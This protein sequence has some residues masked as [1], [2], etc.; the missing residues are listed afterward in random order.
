MDYS[1]ILSCCLAF[2]LYSNTFEA[3]FVYDDRRAIITNPDLQPSTPWL[4]IFLNDFWGTPMSD[5]GS[6]G[7]YR[8]LA[9][10]TFRL[11]YLLHGYEPF[12]YHLVNVILH[13]IATGLFVKI[14]KKILP[15]SIADTSATISGLLFAAHPIHTEAVSA[16]VGRA[17][18]L[19]AIAFMLSFLTYVSHVKYRNIYYF[20][21]EYSAPQYDLRFLKKW[22]KDILK[23]ASIKIVKK[24]AEI[25]INTQRRKTTYVYVKVWSH[26]VA[27][28]VLAVVG[29]LCKETGICV[30]GVSFI[31]DLIITSY[32]KQKQ[33]RSLLLLSLCT[34]ATLSARFY[35]GITPDFARADNPTAKEDCLLTRTFTFLYLP[36]FNFLL[37]VY[38]HPLSF[39][40]SMEAVP[41]VTGVLDP[42]NSVSLI[43]Y[44]TI[45][46]TLY[47]CY[48][49]MIPQKGKH[50]MK[51]K[52][53]T[54]KTNQRNKKE[55]STQCAFCHETFTNLHSSTCRF[56]N[57][58]N[59][60]N[61]TWS[62]C[63][64]MAV[65]SPR[66]NLTFEGTIIFSLT[67]LVIPFLPA[68]NMFFYVGFV[69]AERLLYLPSAGF[70]LLFGLFA[71]SCWK[72][73]ANSRKHFS[74]VF[75]VV[76]LALSAKTVW[77]NFDWYDEEAL[78][79]AAV[80]VNPPKALGNLGS[81]L[82]TA[83]RLREAETAYREALAYKPN[84]ADVHYNLGILLQSEKRLD[85]AILSFQRAI[86]FRST[87]A[88]A[89]INLAS[90]LVEAKR[91]EEA[92][93][94]LN[95]VAM[96][97]GTGL[98][99]RRQHDSAKVSALIQLGDLYTEQGR[100]HRALEI[101]TEAA[102]SIPDHY[103]RQKVFNVLGRT[104]YLLNRHEEAERW[105]RAAMRAGPDNV[106]S[107]IGYGKLI[108]RNVSRSSEAE[109]WFRKA[110]KIA[111]ND[112]A[113]YH[114]YGE[115]LVYRHQFSE[116]AD[117]YEKAAELAP[118]DYQLSVAAAIAMRQA[119]RPLEAEKWYRR[120]VALKPTDA[121]NLSNLGA[122][123]HLN[124]K[125]KEAAKNYEASLQLEPND[126]ITL[127]NLN[128]LHSLMT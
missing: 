49:R 119:S 99:D 9:V 74:V 91:S 48:S 117:M 75:F 113:V 128:R 53:V 68:T 73:Y 102:T 43:F 32:A 67:L 7:S 29:M 28:I 116:A 84:M 100:L 120:A 14:T 79:R 106:A 103:P 115:F 62:A 46:T 17:D 35:G 12:G 124:G 123:L 97:D 59:N 10:I 63:D 39:D 4:D 60:N 1:S 11:N 21:P 94:I 125:Y 15:K 107:Y 126:S 127:T 3:G 40:W 30:L 77:R 26:F 37:L 47:V 88:L 54:I 70:C 66:K 98:K 31:Y 13:V 69:V 86:H 72:R 101:Y 16:I 52:M 85:E 42:R 25:N 78:F 20:T 8:P 65:T 58:N 2:I 122:I 81:V 95:Q 41:R 105:Y 24:S 112:P 61:N 114:N 93:N 104:L 45:L 23:T 111:P 82:N 6:H 64:C 34:L 5:S 118:D 51:H 71:A 90:V 19:S 110:Q 83:G 57:N 44:G 55:T 109:R 38:P 33:H 76:L 56:A 18:L 108:A 89:Y 22:Q 96:L 87:L 27:S 92:V 36:V 121:Q 50:C 80:P